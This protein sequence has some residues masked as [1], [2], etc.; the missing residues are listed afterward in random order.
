MYLHVHPPQMKP[1]PPH[2]HVRS[3]SQPDDD[4]DGGGDGALCV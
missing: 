3:W 2:V 1:I 4:D